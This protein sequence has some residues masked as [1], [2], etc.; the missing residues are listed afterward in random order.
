MRCGTS[1]LFER[2]MVCLMST[3]NS[4]SICRGS[5]VQCNDNWFWKHTRGTKS[6]WNEKYIHIHCENVAYFWSYPGVQFNRREELRETRN[7]N[8]PTPRFYTILF[9]ACS[10]F[11]FQIGERICQTQ[12]PQ[13]F[14]SF[15]SIVGV[16]EYNKRY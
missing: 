6:M 9:S 3:Q 2:R 1:I 5:L 15:L 4:S 12:P 16:R 10:T 8:L 7:G 11:S 13:H 14:F